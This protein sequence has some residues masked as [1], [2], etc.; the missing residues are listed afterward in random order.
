MGLYVGGVT[1]V[2]VGVGAVLLGSYFVASAAGR[3]DIYC[4]MPSVPCAYKNDAPRMTGGAVMMALGSVLAAAGIPMWLVGSQYVLVPKGEQPKAEVHALP[5][6]RL[7]PLGG[8]LPW[9][10]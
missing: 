3:I 6:V 10:F 4:D 8:G 9:R 7:G 2:I 1:S 5:E